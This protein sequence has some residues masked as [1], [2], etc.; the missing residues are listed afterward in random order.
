MIYLATCAGKHHSFSEDAV[1]VGSEVLLETMEKLQMPEAGFIC[2][3]DGVGGNYGGADASSFICN[4]LANAGVLQ[5]EEIKPFLVNTNEELLAR[6][7]ENPKLSSMATTLTGVYKMQDSYTLVHIGNTRAYVKQ[8]KYLKQVTADHTTYSWLKSSGR[9]EAAEKSNKSEITNCF[10]G[11]N[12]LLLGKMVVRGCQPFCLM[13]ITSDG[14]HEF[15]DLD[16]LEDILNGEGSYND[17]CN[18]ILQAAKAAGS[19]DDVTVVLIC[20]E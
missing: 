14:V 5:P 11:G 13:M 6:A 4:T 9:Q 18:D 20:D 2:V 16:T 7:K 1:V 17:K 3:A 15:V 12:P 19:E 8:G 10:G